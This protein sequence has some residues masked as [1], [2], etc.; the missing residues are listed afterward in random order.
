MDSPKA[1]P[2]PEGAFVFSESQEAA[3]M[4]TDGELT[5]SHLILSLQNKEDK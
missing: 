5:V 4:K 2:F 1:K 3:Q